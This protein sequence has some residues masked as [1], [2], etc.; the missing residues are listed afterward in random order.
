[1]AKFCSNCGAQ[2][3]DAAQFCPGCGTK[4]AEPQQAQQQTPPPGAEQAQQQG[5]QQGQQNQYQQQYQYQQTPPQQ[6]RAQ[7]EFNDAMRMNDYTAQ[8]HPQD[9]ANNKA[10]AILS[11]IGILTLIPYFAE[12]QSPYVRFHAVQGMYLFLTA[13]AVSICGSILGVIFAFIPFIGAVI[14]GLIG[15]VFGLLGLGCFALMIVGI[16]YAATDKAKDLPVIHKF[17][18]LGWFK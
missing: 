18:K 17:R 6:G 14:S 15:F 1:M 10:M 11:Y 4:T 7:Q 5:Q 9:I 12:K 8:F 2:L 13:L 3:D 16:V